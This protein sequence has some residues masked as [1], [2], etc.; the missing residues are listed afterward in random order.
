MFDDSPVEQRN[1]EDECLHDLMS[2]AM[3][4]NSENLHDS[5]DGGSEVLKFSHTVA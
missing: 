2:D 5:V 3:A 4:E 1:T